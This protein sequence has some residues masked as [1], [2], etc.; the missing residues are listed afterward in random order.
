MLFRSGAFTGRKVASASNLNKAASALKGV[1]RSAQQQSDVS[2]AKETVEAYKKQ[3]EELN[4]EFEREADALAS[5]VDPAT[6]TLE[7]VLLKPKKT[8]IEIRLVALAWAPY[9]ISGGQA[10]PAW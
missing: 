5:R 3:L 2:R 4:A 7:T 10:T 6:E 8:D 9:R 1:G